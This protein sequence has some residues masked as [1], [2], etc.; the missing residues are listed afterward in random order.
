MKTRSNFTLVE[1]LVTMGV[2]CVLLMVSMQIFGSAGK[3]WTRSEQKSNTFAAARTA[4]EF[5][6]A[7]I[8]SNAYTEDM[9]FEISC[10]TSPVYDRIFFPTVMPMNRKD[11]DGN[12]R[13]K[14]S[15]RF[16]AFDLVRTTSDP[17]CGKLKMLIYSD[18][19][20]NSF[21]NLMP[22]YGA[23]RRRRGGNTYST[24]EVAR[25][26]VRN[27]IFSSSIAAHNEIEIIENVIDFRLRP[28]EL[29]ATKHSAITEVTSGSPVY[30]PP[31]LLEIEISVLDSKESFRKWRNA[32]NAAEREEI[33]TEAG[34]TFRRA[35]LL[36]DR[37]RS[38]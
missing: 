24:A 12:E 21:L 36:G 19:R 14:F 8:Q 5:V 27:T 28:Y 11:N 34:Y 6:A 1:L 25:N 16:V 30:T 31:Y 37:R 7:R 4:M 10:S 2:F 23:N 9:P 35:V 3:L 22:P 15:M 13:D 20:N 38:F 32:A 26:H 33:E 29:P 18:E 17:E